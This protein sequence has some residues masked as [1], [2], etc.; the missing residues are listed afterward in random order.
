MR[1]THDESVR[2]ETLAESERLDNMALQKVS[3]QRVA[4]ELNRGFDILT[5][6]NLRGGLAKM[7]ST[8]FM[9]VPT[10]AWDK[11]T[12]RGQENHS[13]L[14]NN[15]PSEQQSKHLNLDF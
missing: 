11:I 5:N 14:N 8:G 15:A 10:K 6:G 3:H 4:E 12:P 13:A 9:K 7:H 2:N 1:Y